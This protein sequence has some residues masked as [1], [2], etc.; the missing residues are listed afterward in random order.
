MLLNGEEWKPM[1]RSSDSFPCEKKTV[2]H[3]PAKAAII[4]AIRWSS[5]E[6]DP[7][8]QSQRRIY[9]PMRRNQGSACRFLAS[10]FT[11][12]SLCLEKGAP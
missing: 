2:H 4:N 3:P 12:P 7:P 1:R 8:S 9:Q 6:L 11:V 5:P 10:H